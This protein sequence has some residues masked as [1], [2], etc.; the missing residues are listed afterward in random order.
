[1]FITQFWMLMHYLS[2]IED[3]QTLVM[4]SGHPLGMFP[5][6]PTAP[7]MVITNGMVSRIVRGF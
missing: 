2:V 4:Y 7:R 6:Q 3:D 5:S 1:M